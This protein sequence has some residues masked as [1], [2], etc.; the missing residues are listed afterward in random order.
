VKFEPGSYRMKVQS[1]TAAL[2]Y[3]IGTVKPH[4]PLRPRV[5]CPYKCPGKN[6]R[7]CGMKESGGLECRAVGS[8]LLCKTYVYFSDVLAIVMANRIFVTP[9]K[10]RATCSICHLTEQLYLPAAILPPPQ[11]VP[12]YSKS[13]VGPPK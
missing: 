10:P 3:L 4:T 8:R 13:R 6:R 5:Q 12:H 11:K 7:Q 1:V 9:V 2:T